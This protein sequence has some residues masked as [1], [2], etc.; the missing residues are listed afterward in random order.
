VL[1]RRMLIIGLVAGGT[2]FVFRPAVS[3]V[4][5][6]FTPVDFLVPGGACDTHIHVVGDPQQ[7][8]QWSGRAFTLG[9]ASVEETREVHRQLHIDRIVIV[10]S[11]VYGT[12]N[13]CTL[14]ALRRLGERSRGVVLIDDKTFGKP[15]DDMHRLG[16][17]GIRLGFGAFKQAE[18][19]SVRQRFQRAVQQVA[20]RKWH[21]QIIAGLDVIEALQD[22][23]MAAP[24]PIVFDHFGLAKASLGIDQ[25]GFGT[26]LK[27]IRAGK[28]YVKISAPYRISNRPDYSDVAPLAKALI[29]ANPQR[30]LWGSDWPHPTGG[31]PGHAALEIDPRQQIDDGLVLNLLP[32]W[33]PDPALRT[34]I[35]VENPARLYGF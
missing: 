6:I 26:L 9:V 33:A 10:T 21:I 34:T 27:L 3:I 12:D 13:T 17:R 8:P 2:E 1:S 29:A 30:I 4:A 14:D 31:R 18:L 11:G 16:V 35:L 25:P 7:F 15:L 23:V 24:V 28:A 32:V 5:G 19:G 22:E 20:P